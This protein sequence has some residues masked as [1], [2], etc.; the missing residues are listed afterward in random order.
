AGGGRSEAAHG[1]PAAAAPP[2]EAPSRPALGGLGR[3]RVPPP[4]SSGPASPPPGAAA[5]VPLPTREELTL[6]WADHI[7]GRL[8]PV[9]KACFAAGRFAAVDDQGVTFALPTDAMRRKCESRRHEVE[10][11]LAA[12]LGRHARLRLTVDGTTVADVTGG[13]VSDSEVAEAVDLEELADVP[14][15]S[16]SD[17]DRLSE[18][19]P[20]AELVEDQRPGPDR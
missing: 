18:V 16:R 3:D 15:D 4:G 19:F 7:L 14:P 11:E 13:D 2:T 20:G 6:A 1:E 9:A 5:S 17:L 10:A 12:F 8:R